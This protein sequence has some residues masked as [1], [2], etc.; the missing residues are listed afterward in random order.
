MSASV[1]RDATEFHVV[2]TGP[3]HQMSSRGLVVRI[4]GFPLVSEPCESS[5]LFTALTCV[6]TT[7]NA[8]LILPLTTASMLAEIECGTAAEVMMAVRYTSETGSS[9][10]A[11]LVQPGLCISASH[12]SPPSSRSSLTQG[13]SDLLLAD[14][15][16]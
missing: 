12:R 2:I 11:N 4:N 8:G 16:D 10:F 14:D 3:P 7:G 6:L 15:V 13:R 1:Y 9:L 5:H